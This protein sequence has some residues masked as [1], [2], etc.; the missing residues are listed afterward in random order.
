MKKLFTLAALI[1]SI[2]AFKTQ[3]QNAAPTQN[4]RGTV[5]DKQSQMQIPGANVI[6]IGS[7]PIKGAVS[8]ADGRFKITEVKVGRYDLKVSYMGYKEIILPNIDVNAGKEVVLEI[9]LEENISSLQEVVVSGTKK[10][11]TQNEMVSVSGRSFSMEEVNRYAG[12]RSD[13]SRL[14]ANFAGVSSPDDSRNDIVD[15][16]SV[17]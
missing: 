13:P 2:F 16:K 14:A 9:G 12:G 11:E 1:L 7:D 10:N 8:D 15:R 5:I 6:L 4:I 3:A 17:V